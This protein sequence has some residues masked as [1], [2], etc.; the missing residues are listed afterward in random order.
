MRKPGLA[1]S[2]AQPTA[3]T[4]PSVE[5]GTQCS[6]I[7]ELLGHFILIVQLYGS[8][9]LQQNSKIKCSFVSERSYAP[10]VDNTGAKQQMSNDSCSSLAVPG[11]LRPVCGMAWQLAV[12]F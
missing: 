10:W 5:D 9:S 8:D 3:L 4:A 7:R 2:T 12:L 11:D 1:S 6:C